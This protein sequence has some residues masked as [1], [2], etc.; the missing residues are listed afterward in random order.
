MRRASTRHGYYGTPTYES[1]TAMLAR[2]RYERHP[3][4][5]HYGGRGIEVCERWLKFENFLADMG[6][7]PEGLTLDRI[8]HNDGY[9]PGN[10]RWATET[11]Q[12]RNTR[13]NR[14]VTHEGR[15]MC[16]SAWAEELGVG[17]HV[18]YTWLSKGL[19]VAE[20]K[21]G[22]TTGEIGKRKIPKLTIEQAI[23][24]RARHK[25]GENRRALAAE[26]DVSLHVVKDILRGRSYRV[27]RFGGSL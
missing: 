26:F 10:C 8:R 23:T 11:E 14:Y 19:G 7:R 16:A 5:K 25:S 17:R 24:I 2:C 1:W 22:I 27:Q 9:E 3:H 13:T 12:H 18:I 21:D 20:I 15:T 6:E 4:F